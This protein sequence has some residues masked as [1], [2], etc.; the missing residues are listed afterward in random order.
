MVSRLL[1][2]LSDSQRESSPEKA[3]CHL[4]CAL[5]LR[6]H[7]AYAALDFSAAHSMNDETPDPP[8]RPWHDVWLKPRRVFRILANMPI[9]RVDHGLAAAQGTVNFLALCRGGN[10]AHAGGVPEILGAALIIGPLTGILGLYLM[11]AVYVR[12]GRTVGSE[13]TKAQ[14]F[15]VLAYSGVP[16][17]V[18]LGLW[19]IAAGLAGDS[20]FLETPRAGL[21]GFLSLLLRVQLLAH[22]ALLLW[23]VLLQVMG[24]SEMQA[25]TVPRALGLW[26]LGQLLVFLLAILLVLVLEVLGFS[27]GAA[28]S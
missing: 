7:I 16:L 24:L 14:I 4:G 19:L 6:P 2:G 22:G 9:G 28:G 20:A 5:E 26:C 3:G 18:S 10:F 25:V 13:A 17:V 23:S 1:A 8:L 11:T 27:G 12:L 15:H 21:D